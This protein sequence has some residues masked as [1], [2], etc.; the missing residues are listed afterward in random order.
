MDM[1]DLN[2]V[3]AN[4]PHEGQVSEED[5]APNE[6]QEEKETPAESPTEDKPAEESPSPDGD[7]SQD[8]SNNLPF[9]KHP[10]WK[11]MYQSKKQ[12]ED[13]VRQLRSQMEEKL[14]RV[15]QPNTEVPERWKRLLGE[16]PDA[17]AMWREEQEALKR[18]IIE[19]V[20]SLGEAERQAQIAAQ[21]ESE[22][23]V[24]RSLNE[25]ED[26]GKTFDRNELVKFL[27][28]FKQKYK[29]VP[30]DEDGNID[31]RAGYELFSQFKSEKQE[32][33]KS[34]MTARKRI[35]DFTTSN[36]SQRAEAPERDFLT[37]SDLR[38]QDWDTLFN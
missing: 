11:E 27:V 25:L 19:Q 5:L 14:A 31:F 4:V 23:Y 10:R 38:S 17:W 1:L 36:G 9:H 33:G 22:T 34:K 32:A 29:T 6:E 28:D 16:N 2:Q 15:E 13:E 12:L 3:L 8:D 20:R 21:K 18:D 26:E 7:S 30:M 37:S 24:E 35:A